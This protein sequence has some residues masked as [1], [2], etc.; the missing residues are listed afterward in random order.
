MERVAVPAASPRA[1][2]CPK[3]ALPMN[4]WELRGLAL[5]HC[6]ACKGLWF[7]AGELEQYLAGSQAHFEESGLDP[8]GE[9]SLACPRCPGVRLG[10]ATVDTVALDV[11]PRCRG[12]FL[13]LGEV[14]ALLGAVSRGDYAADPGLSRLDNQ[15]LG[16]YIAARVGESEGASG[17]EAR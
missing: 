17:D 5:D 8:V 9:T 11:C 7:D 16:L 4:V 2:M 15:A 6:H 12:S 3:C 1:L 14:H 10:R 13:D